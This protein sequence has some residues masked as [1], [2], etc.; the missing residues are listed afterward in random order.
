[1]KRR[2]KRTG[3][4]LLL[5]G[6]LAG[7]LSGCASGGG[8]PLEEEEPPLN[9]PVEVA[10]VRLEAPPLRVVVMSPSLAEIAADLGYADRL[11][12]RTEECDYPPSV[13]ALPS[14]GKTLMPDRSGIVALNASLVLAQT[15]LPEETAVYLKER[16][17][18]VAV[19]PAASTYE[20]LLTVYSQV[21]SL[22]AGEQ[23]GTQAG[24]ALKQTLDTRLE[25]LSARI[26]AEESPVV[27][28]A[29][30]GTGRVATGDTFLG[31]V[32]ERVGL[33]NAAA[34]GTGWQLPEG[35][36]AAYLFCPSDQLETVQA[37]PAFQGLSAVA[38][39]RVTGVSSALTERQGLRLAEGMEAMV[40]ALYPP[41]APEE[42]SGTAEA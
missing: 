35:A 36:D 2:G 40:T 13:A 12:G 42:T 11:C 41:E 28:Y 6:L 10:G 4:Y 32:M 20:E 33:Y 16:G 3:I 9:Y 22:F 19:I 18:P 23:A 34:A 1:M 5:A 29:V 15:E 30:D 27:L 8:E 37:L 21:G 14:V 17:V 38:E 7:L 31:S 39:G 24:T 26:S 25:A